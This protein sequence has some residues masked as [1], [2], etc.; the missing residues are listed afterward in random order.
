MSLGAPHDTDC[1]CARCEN[2][3]DEWIRGK[4]KQED[5]ADVLA[6]VPTA[7]AETAQCTGP[8][9]DGKTCPVHKHSAYAG[10]AAATCT[11]Q[12]L[13]PG[14]HGKVLDQKCPVHGEAG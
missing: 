11:C 7:G 9:A 3:R 6:V 8:F 10:E 12:E 1:I 13:A 4:A 14:S 5:G 2:R